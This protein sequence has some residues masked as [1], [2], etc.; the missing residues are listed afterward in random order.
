MASAGHGRAW[1][2]DGNEVFVD[3]RQSIKRSKVEAIG[4]FESLL[5]YPTRK[6]ITCCMIKGSVTHRVNYATE[7]R[8]W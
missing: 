2:H 7:L 4:D 5:E 1:T 3:T 8:K 6:D